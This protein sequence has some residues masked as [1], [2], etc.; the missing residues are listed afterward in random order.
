MARAGPRRQSTRQALNSQHAPHYSVQDLADGRVQSGASGALLLE[1]IRGGWISRGILLLVAGIALAVGGLN[2]TPGS[3]FV[4]AGFLG[5]RL[6][7]LMGAGMVVIG[8]VRK[9]M[10]AG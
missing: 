7:M 1:M 10:R 2:G 9:K 5:G 3:W 8:I 6:L 4:P